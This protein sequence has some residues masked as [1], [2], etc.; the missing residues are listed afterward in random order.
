MERRDVLKGLGVTAGAGVI[1]GAGIVASSDSA[2]AT[3]GGQLNDT[4]VKTDDGSVEY[5]ATQTTGRVQWDGFDTAVRQAKIVNRVQYFRNGSKQKE[6]KINETNK[7]TPS[8]GVWQGGDGNGEQFESGTEG[9]IAADADWGIA[10]AG[11][12][13]SYDSGYGLPSD[14]APTD[15]LEVD[16][17]GDTKKTK[18]VLVSEYVLYAGSGAELTGRSEFPDRPVAKSSTV[19]TVTNEEATSS[20]GDDDAQNDSDDSAEAA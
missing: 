7:F 3:A 19:L 18:V 5:V 11:R 20:F 9:Y 2:V 12:Q 4:S 17:D 1:G 8:D 16:T 13:N 10:Q 14:P 15:P 6:Y